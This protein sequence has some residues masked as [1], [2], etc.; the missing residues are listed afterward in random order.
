[1]RAH[2]R[3]HRSLEV[4]VDAT[5]TCLGERT[6]GEKKKNHLVFTVVSKGNGEAE[7][8]AEEANV[9]RGS[10]SCIKS[11]EHFTYKMIRRGKNK[12]SGTEGHDWVSPK[13]RCKV[14]EKR[15]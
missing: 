9:A 1:M 3:K 4:V 13:C 6:R 5:Q 2:R 12:R 14:L 11:V 7:H 8:K 15:V 10:G